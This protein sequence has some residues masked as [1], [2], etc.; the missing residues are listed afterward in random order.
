[1]NETVNRK[2]QKS[3]YELCRSDKMKKLLEGSL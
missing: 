1:M 2:V 3:N